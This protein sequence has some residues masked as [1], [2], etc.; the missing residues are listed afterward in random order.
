[1]SPF[2]AVHLVFVLL[3]L[4]LVPLVLGAVEGVGRIERGMLVVVAL[5]LAL[6]NAVLGLGSVVGEGPLLAGLSVPRF[7]A[8][9]VATPLLVLPVV[10]IAARHGVGWATHDRTPLAARGLAAVLV[11]VGVLDLLALELVPIL[12]GGVLRYRDASGGAPVGAIVTVLVALVAGTAIARRRGSIAVLV[13]AVVM[14]VGA[15]LDASREDVVVGALAELVLIACLALAVR[16][17]AG[18]ALTPSGR[19]DASAA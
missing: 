1:M 13:G 10:G 8:H 15:G 18:A 19:S 5:A 17:A 2:A 16:R 6:D 3:F 9:A 4:G 7:V 12:A 14:L 11:V